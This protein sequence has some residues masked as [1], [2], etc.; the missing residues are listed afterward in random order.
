MATH[1]AIDSSFGQQTLEGRF[2]NLVR[3]L[4]TLCRHHG[5]GTQDLMVSLDASQQAAVMFAAA[6]SFRLRTASVTNS[7]RLPVLSSPSTANFTQTSVT[8]P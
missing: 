6:A 4:E 7:T 1:L 8:T 3:A 5:L 2:V